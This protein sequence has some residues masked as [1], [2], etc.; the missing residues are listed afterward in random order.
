MASSTADQSNDLFIQ[1]LTIK[2]LEEWVKKQQQQIEGSFEFQQLG[3]VKRTLQMLCMAKNELDTLNSLIMQSYSSINKKLTDRVKIFKRQIQIIQE[4]KDETDP[5][6]IDSTLSLFD[7]Q[8]Q[9]DKLEFAPRV[10][11]HNVTTIKSLDELPDTRMYWVTDVQQFAIKICGMVLRG[12]IGTVYPSIHTANGHVIKINACRYGRM[13]RNIGSAE[14]CTYYH[15]PVEM[16]SEQATKFKEIRNFTNGSWL[17]TSEPVKENNKMMRHIGSRPTIYSD[18][19]NVSSNEA[20][21]WIDQTIHSIL[22]T[23]ILHQNK[24]LHSPPRPTHYHH[25]AT[26]DIHPRSKKESS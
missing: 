1:S 21:C 12:N 5:L 24:K 19:H 7:V 18:L 17:Y 6:A 14:G 23:L 4:D 26:E 9:Q 16:G 15:D 20:Q 8:Q 3:S 10:Q 11:A 2:Q 25:H 22:V 13:C